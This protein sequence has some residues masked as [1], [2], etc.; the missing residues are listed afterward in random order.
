MAMD[1]LGASRLAIQNRDLSCPRPDFALRGDEL[2][3]T[4][5]KG[6]YSTFAPIFSV[7]TFKRSSYSRAVGSP[8]GATIRRLTDMSPRGR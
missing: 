6:N 3:Y 5:I 1:R 4:S 8:G 7:N 2:F